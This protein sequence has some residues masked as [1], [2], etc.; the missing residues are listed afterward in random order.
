MIQKISLKAYELP[1]LFG[2]GDHIIEIE[3]GSICN[4]FWGDNISMVSAIVGKNGVGKSSILRYIKDNSGFKRINESHSNIIYFSP[5]LDYRDN[6]NFDVD[7]ND[8]SLDTILRRDLEHTFENEKESSENGWML[9]PKQDLEYLHTAR[10]MDFLTSNICK[11]HP[12]FANI[13]EGLKFGTGEVSLRGLKLK[14]ITNNDFHNTP[15]KFR[16]VI[17]EIIKKC[18]YEI[19]LWHELRV[20]TKDNR[21]QNQYEVNAYIFKRNIIL[22]F[23]SV[24]IDFFENDSEYLSRGYIQIK[25]EEDYDAFELFTQFVQNAKL[26]STY[27]S[28]ILQRVFNEAILKL[29]NYIYDLVDKIKDEKSISNKTFSTDYDNLVIIKKFQNDILSDLSRKYFREKTNIYSFLGIQATDRKLSSGENAMLNFYSILYEFIKGV[30]QKEI[31]KNYIL[32]LDEADLGYHPEWKKKFVNS[33]VKSLP[34]FFKFENHHSKI[35]IIFTTHDPL[36]LS[37]IPKQNVLFLDKNSEGITFINNESKET[38]G[39]NIHD[40]LADSFF[41]SDGLIGDFAKEKID[42]TILWLRHKILYKELEELDE[43]NSILKESLQQKLNKIEN[44]N[45]WVKSSKKEKHRQLI[46]LIDEPLLKYKMNEMYFKIY[47]REMNREEAEKKIREI[48]SISGIN[49]DIIR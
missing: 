48:A 1:H 26:A 47:P 6:Y 45:E 17:L 24:L 18:K 19:S 20:F 13:F 38:F 46:D 41:I 22:S 8:I 25:E 23:L 44:N 5:H 49:I 32:L 35:Q 10:Q 37:D 11:E 36:T 33:I 9:N 12:V 4:G 21:V 15:Y 43:K 27:S 28:E 3:F 14:D 16:R 7:P 34:L 31:H 39:A 2:D 42:R 30:D 29:F 40:L